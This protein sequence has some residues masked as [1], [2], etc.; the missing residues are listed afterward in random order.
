MNI[1]CPNCALTFPVLAGMNDADARRFAALMGDLPPTV[2]RPLIEY[3]QLFKPDKSGLKWSKMLKL[4]QDIAPEIIAGEVRRNGRT[5]NATAEQWAEGM[6]QLTG[7]RDKLTL[8]MKSNGY[9]RDIVFGLADRTA[10]QV[11]REHEES[12]RRGQRQDSGNN[13][14]DYVAIRSEIRC[15]ED[16]LAV[17]PESARLSLE[18]QIKELKAKLDAKP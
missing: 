17:A 3:L 5:L 7:R 6:G 4:T 10:A 11:E 18:R 8:P 2:A 12:L 13:S 15:L 16:M 14:L 1:T 9:L